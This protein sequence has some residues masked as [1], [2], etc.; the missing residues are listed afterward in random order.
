M[1]FWLDAFK[2]IFFRYCVGGFIIFDYHP[3]ENWKSFPTRYIIH[4]VWLLYESASMNH[5][6]KLS[7]FGFSSQKQFCV[8]VN[9]VILIPLKLSWNFLSF[10]VHIVISRALE[11]SKS[12][13]FKKSTFSIL[14][15]FLRIFSKF[16]FARII[17]SNYLS[18]ETIFILIGRTFGEILCLQVLKFSKIKIE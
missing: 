3:M 8:G 16:L 7:N 10:G 4:I 17:R 15:E 13:N 2:L 6:I 11:S 14:V 1:L 18:F 12:I 9:V 5:Y